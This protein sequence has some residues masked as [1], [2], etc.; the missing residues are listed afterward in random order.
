MIILDT[1]VVSEPLRP[2]PHEGVVGWLDA[3]A[4]DTLYLTTISLAEVRFGIAALPAGKRRQKL[5]D[6]FEDEVLPL[7]AGRTLGFDEPSTSAYAAL[8][9]RARA[10]GHAIGQVDALIAAIASVHDC[11][12][13]TRD[14]A[15]F[16]AAGVGVINPFDRGH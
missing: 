5:H 10:N 11:T 12:V 3:Q 9:C 14:A 6:R 1:D 4:V 15:P 16:R 8:R 7:F 2:K 13:A